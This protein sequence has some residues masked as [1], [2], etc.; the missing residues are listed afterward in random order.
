MNRYLSEDKNSDVKEDGECLLNERS[1]DLLQRKEFNN[2]W[3][4][5][6][7]TT[8]EQFL[9]KE[10]DEIQS[11]ELICKATVGTVETCKF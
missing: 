10:G 5:E 9:V 8:Q 4:C 3:M 6:D 2:V 1:N 11:E 7:V